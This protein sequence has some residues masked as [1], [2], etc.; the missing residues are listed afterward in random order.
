MA[1]IDKNI[2]E[3]VTER[4]KSPFI[5]SFLLSWSAINW[6]FFAILFLGN[7]PVLERISQAD[8]TLNIDSTYASL[9][10]ASLYTFVWPWVTHLII[11]YQ[12]KIKF[13]RTKQLVK[14]EHEV[15]LAKTKN[16]LAKIRY[17]I[18]E[19]H[20]I[21]KLLK[22]QAN[23]KKQL[24]DQQEFI[25]EADALLAEAEEKSAKVAGFRNMLNFF[26]RDFERFDEE[27][28]RSEEEK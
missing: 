22:T 17:E 9:I 26:Q 6:K 18:N 20:A 4:I 5:F 23:F 8:K 19:Q 27:F 7:L 2:T 14:E 13:M 1:E 21:E 12:S 16:N 25:K 28:V 24:K 15:E 11:S 3:A 10:I